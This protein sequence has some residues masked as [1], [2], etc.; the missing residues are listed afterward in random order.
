MAKK[1]E[2]LEKRTHNKWVKHCEKFLVEV[3]KEIRQG[4]KERGVKLPR[5][6]S[7]S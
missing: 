1:W 6:N 4:F 2:R 7:E 3:R 5:K